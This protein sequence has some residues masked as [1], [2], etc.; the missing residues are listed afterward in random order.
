MAPGVPLFGVTFRNPVLL[1]A[2]TCGFGRAVSSVIRLE[3]LGGFVTKSVTLLPRAGHPPPRVA[4]FGAG[5]LNS[6]GLANPG[7]EAVRRERLPWIG[8]QLPALHV[9][10]SVAGHTVDEYLEV[11]RVLED[12]PGFLGYEL[13]LSCPNDSERSG[14]PFALDPVALGSV[15]EGVR[16]LTPRPLLVKLAPNTPD[17][18]P[19]A[20]AAEQAGADALTL[21]NT[22]PGLLLDPRSG[23]PRL[24][25]GSGGVS[26]PALRPLGLA[27]VRQ[28]RAITDLP[29]VGV[30][31]IVRERDAAAYLEAGAS[32]VQIGTAS[33]SDPRA[34]ERVARRLG[35]RIRAGGA[36]LTD[37]APVR[38]RAGAGRGLGSVACA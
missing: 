24:G 25:A 27:A 26:G 8:A 29:L 28:V 20:R 3:A 2:G 11:V 7:A 13:N 33:F 9:F 19:V 21:V 23:R 6:V 4:E 22:V 35:R 17:F 1:A 18:G 12:G 36:A 34:P 14:L 31:G 5:M 10:V 16:A 15:V 37:S 30:G 38:K 32:L